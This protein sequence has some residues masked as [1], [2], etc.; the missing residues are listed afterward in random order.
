M[1]LFGA[2]DAVVNDHVRH[3]ALVPKAGGDW[4]ADCHDSSRQI[5]NGPQK[6]RGGLA[7]RHENG[8]AEVPPRAQPPQRREQAIGH[9]AEQQRVER[10]F[11]ARH[12]AN[13]PRRRESSQQGRSAPV[14]LDH[15]EVLRARRRA[16]DNA[17]PR[18]LHEQRRADAQ[19]AQFAD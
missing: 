7:V 13:R 18:R 8:A 4:F 5:A 1:E 11:A 9:V 10:T 15:A 12:S 3:E 19:V 2:H 6:T 16:R 14:C 17:G